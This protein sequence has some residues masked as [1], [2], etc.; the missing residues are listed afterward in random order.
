MKRITILFT[1]IFL[2]TTVVFSQNPSIS[3]SSEVDPSNSFNWKTSGGSMSATD[4]LGGHI[5]FGT[6]TPNG[7][8]GIGG[9]L[10]LVSGKGYTHGKIFFKIGTA[11]VAEIRSSNLYINKII[12]FTAPQSKYLDLNALATG[13]SLNVL[14]KL[15]ASDVNLTGGNS[16]F[17]AGTTSLVDIKTALTEI[18]NPLKVNNSISL[19]G[20]K[21]FYTD[22]LK[23]L[24]IRH[25]T[26]TSML[27]IGI[28]QGNGEYHSSAILG[29][30]V[31][32]RKGTGKKVIIGNA[33]NPNYLEDIAT[34]ILGSVSTDGLWVHNNGNSRFG[35]YS[36]TAPTSKLEVQGE[37]SATQIKLSNNNAGNRL[38]WSKTDG[39][40]ITGLTGDGSSNF[41]VLTNNIERLRINKVGEVGIGKAPV[42]GVALNVFGIV[43]ATEIK[44]EA[45]TADF[46]FE[47][48]YQLRPLEEVETFIQENKHLPDVPSAAQMDA[49][50]V[51]LAEMNK[52][53]LMKVEELTLYV[54]QQQ[55]QIDQLLQQK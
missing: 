13:T 24:N 39:T 8:Y 12:N 38:V 55:K 50:G 1:A 21:E 10:T 30:V 42:A 34:G 14:G 43:R 45:Q 27:E 44:V 18:H 4:G 26:Q 53:L 37:L 17:K 9:D 49:N 51:N 52:L 3:P 23:P 6:G 11:N 28:A 7:T 2:F 22:G 46:V 5:I 35:V 36:T 31:L 47:S 33:W 20:T 15:V 16:F 41:M 19:W 48:D 32:R 54:I 40:E 29:D 25:S